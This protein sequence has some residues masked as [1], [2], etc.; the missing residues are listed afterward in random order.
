MLVMLLLM[1]ICWQILNAYWDSF[2]LQITSALL[3]SEVDDIKKSTRYV[4][5]NWQKDYCRP[6]QRFHAISLGKV[7]NQRVQKLLQLNVEYHA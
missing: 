7:N 3:S 5:K 2:F 6:E 1:I 4:H